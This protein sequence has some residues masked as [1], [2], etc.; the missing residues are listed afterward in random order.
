MTEGGGE[1][2]GNVCVHVSLQCKRTSL[3]GTYAECCQKNL[4]LPAR[5]WHETEAECWQISE[6]ARTEQQ[7]YESTPAKCY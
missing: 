5:S 1:A 7:L 2:G 3:C 6:T 4:F